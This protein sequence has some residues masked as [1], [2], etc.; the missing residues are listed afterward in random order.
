LEFELISSK[1]RVVGSNPSRDAT[2]S[3]FALSEALGTKKG[4]CLKRNGPKCYHQKASS[5]GSYQSKEFQARNVA[6]SP[7][8]ASNKPISYQ[9]GEYE[10]MTLQ[11]AL[12][13]Y[14]TYARPEGK[15]P[16][17][18]RWIM[19]SITYFADFLGHASAG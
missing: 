12:A 17:T 14:K 6:Q 9:C 7:G 11:D 18:V 13:A 19:S 5:A 16:K 3:I 2:A 8:N 4:N 15:S 10:V 1:Q